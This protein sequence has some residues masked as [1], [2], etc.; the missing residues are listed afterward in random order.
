MSKYKLGDVVRYTV[1]LDGE[2]IAVKDGFYVVEY[3]DGSRH[4]LSEEEMECLV[5]LPK[6]NKE[7][8]KAEKVEELGVH[9]IYNK[10]EDVQLSKN[11]HLSEFECKC[12]R[13][14]CKTTIVDKG[15]IEKLQRLRDKVGKLK[16]TSAYRCEAHNKAVGGSKKSQHRNGTATDI[17]PLEESLARVTAL[18]ESMFD[19]L[20]T[21]P[22][23]G[24]IHIDS[25]G[26]KARWV[27]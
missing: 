9:K 10:G 16:I 21:Y 25:R 26:S 4:T 22:G 3:E 7:V 23:K 5:K 17:V 1:S 19:G 13:D 15:H 14:D 24:F 11:F 20:G 2:V 27:G 18:A 12:G 8:W 6:E